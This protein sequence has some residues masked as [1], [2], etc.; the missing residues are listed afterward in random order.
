[1][2]AKLRSREGKSPYLNLR[3]LNF[4]FFNGPRYNF[5]TEKQSEVRAA[6]SRTPNMGAALR[7]KQD[8]PI[9]HTHCVSYSEAE[10]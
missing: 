1:M 9:R 6:N 5:A 2:G 10:L 4:P 3:S 8:V 7:P